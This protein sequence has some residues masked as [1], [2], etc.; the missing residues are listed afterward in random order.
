MLMFAPEVQGLSEASLNW[1]RRIIWSE[2]ISR[3]TLNENR[4]QNDRSGADDDIGS[5]WEQWHETP[6]DDV[7]TFEIAREADDVRLSNYSPK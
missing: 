5:A 2:S 7:E 6:T 4:S 1:T 3:L